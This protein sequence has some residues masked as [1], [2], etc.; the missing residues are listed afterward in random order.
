MER[1]SIHQSEEEIRTSD[2]Q[3]DDMNTNEFLPRIIDESLIP[4]INE[5]SSDITNQVQSSPMHDDVSQIMNEPK[6]TIID[7]TTSYPTNV[8]LPQAFNECLSVDKS[9]IPL[10]ST[11]E[12]VLPALN[13]DAS[14][15]S[16]E[17]NTQTSSSSLSS[18]L[19]LLEDD[20]VLFSLENLQLS[21]ANTSDP[22]S[23]DCIVVIPCSDE[24]YEIDDTEEII[25]NNTT[26]SNDTHNKIRDSSLENST[27]SNR[28]ISQSKIS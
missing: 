12:V 1:E 7:Q 11:D 4:D 8:D 22:V 27:L 24:E 13:N 21:T 23:Q 3:S 26:T 2:E 10:E 6:V 18:D 9:K 16:N 5:P 14:D 15:I 20:P 28:S 19:P 17:E 25:N